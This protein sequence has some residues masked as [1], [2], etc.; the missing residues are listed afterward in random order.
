MK[1]R[2]LFLVV[3]LV[4]FNCLL[5][6]AYAHEVPDPDQK[7][8]ICFSMDWEG[9]PMDGGS[10]TVYRVGDIAED[11]G[12]YTFTLV[13]DLKGTGVTLDGE[14]QKLAAAA[15]ALPPITADIKNGKAVFN[16]LVPG[17]YV[18]TQSATEATP[19]FLP[20]QPFLISLPQWE[21][22]SYVYDL[23]ADPKVAP[24]PEPT[25][26]PKPTEPKP[27][28]PSLPQTGQTNWPVPLLAVC[29]LVLI[30]MGGVMRSGKRDERET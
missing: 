26:P 28:E 23:T 4:L 25:E 22:D 3:L 5:S 16:D 30:M 11:D 17:L 15:K 13:R 6:P 1:K 19:G 12:D 21:N 9:E 20:S 2:I 7:G 18:V 27:T 14:V 24:E 29:G 10:L 8:S